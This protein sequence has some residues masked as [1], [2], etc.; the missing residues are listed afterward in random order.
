MEKIKGVWRL[1]E[2]DGCN[3]PTLTMKL[4]RFVGDLESE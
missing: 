4:L 3:M 2:Y 1:E